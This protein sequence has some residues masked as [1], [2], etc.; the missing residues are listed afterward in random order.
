MK[1]GNCRCG[2]RIFFNNHTC[3]ACD[4]VL[5]RCDECDSLASFTPQS[6][7]YRCDSCDEDVHPCQNREYEVCN[8][9]IAGDGICTWCEFTTDIP[10]LSNPDNVA[11]WARL[12][13]AKRRLLLQLKD[14]GFPPFIENLQETHPLSFQFLA[15]T[16][17]AEGKPQ[18]TITG[19]ADGVITIN[20]AEAD[21]VHRERTRVNL[22][23][24]QRTLIGHMRHEVGHYIDW[25]WAMKIDKNGYHELFGDPESVDYSEAMQHHYDNGAPENWA[26]EH[27]SAY[28]TMHPW[29]DFAE[30][31]NAYLD[32][33]AIAT[34]ANNLGRTKFELSAAADGETLVKDVLDIVLE[35]NE[36]NFDLGLLPLFP[37]QLPPSVRTKLNYVHSLR[38]DR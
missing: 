17:D 5:G 8:S 15:D 16:F 33:M 20:L 27:V 30:T 38:R 12:E 28:A 14:L 29:E 18:K 31:V 35:V 19:H 13:T 25:A 34:T 11:R 10:D 26:D 3:V 21:S 37:E 9:F 24:P 36:Y 7:T 32:I 22:G 2:N 23:E 1:T 4:A 6:P